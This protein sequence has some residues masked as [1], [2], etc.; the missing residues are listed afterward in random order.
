METASAGSTTD[1]LLD[2]AHSLLT[3]GRA[4][5]PVMI[6]ATVV[7]SGELETAWGHQPITMSAYHRVWVAALFHRVLDGLEASLILCTSRL[8]TEARAHTRVPFE[9]LV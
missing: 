6:D 5:V 9:H 4:R 7:A 3:T 2:R 8:D 1:Q